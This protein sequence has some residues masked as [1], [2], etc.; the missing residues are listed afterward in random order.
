MPGIDYAALHPRISIRDVLELLDF[1]P[2]KPSAGIACVVA[3][4]CTAVR[5]RAPPLRGLPRH[6]SLLLPPLPE[7]PAISLNCGATRKT[8]PSSTRPAI[9]ARASTFPVPEIHR[10]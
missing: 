9:S 8:F 2:V 6:R 5:I 1:Q 4:R 10:W 3:V 7:P